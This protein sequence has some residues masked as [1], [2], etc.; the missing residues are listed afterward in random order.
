MLVIEMIEMEVGPSDERAIGGGPHGPMGVDAGGG[1]D[2]VGSLDAF[3]GV[4]FE[5]RVLEEGGAVVDDLVD[6]EDSDHLGDVGQLDRREVEGRI[7]GDGIWAHAF[8]R[9]A[10]VW[11][12]GGC[13]NHLEVLGLLGVNWLG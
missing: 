1:E 3:L 4:G 12:S 8:G 10:C 13:C 5:V 2:I 7:G 9:L 11:S 6:V